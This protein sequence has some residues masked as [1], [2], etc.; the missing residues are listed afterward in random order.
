MMELNP[1][2]VKIDDYKEILDIVD[3]VRMKVEKA[4]K[5]VIKLNEIKTQEDK[6]LD[7]WET[8]LAEVSTKVEDMKKTLFHPNY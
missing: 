7:K 1:V 2:F 4:K 8:Q 5:A 3:V 6:E